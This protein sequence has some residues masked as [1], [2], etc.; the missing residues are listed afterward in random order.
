MAS[1]SNQK[2]VKLPNQVG[3]GQALK[4]V[5]CLILVSRQVC[6]I[7]NQNAIRKYHKSRVIHHFQIKHS[8]GLDTFRIHPLKTIMSSPEEGLTD[9]VAFSY[10][11]RIGKSTCNPPCLLVECKGSPTCLLI[12]SSTTSCHIREFSG[13]STQ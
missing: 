2:L 6:A 4:A 8:Y 3:Y 1:L 13:F 10:L 11:T 7:K 12:Q 5:D 9:A